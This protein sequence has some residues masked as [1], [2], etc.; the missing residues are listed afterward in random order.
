MTNFVRD[1]LIDDTSELLEARISSDG[2]Y[3]PEEFLRN[4]ADD[5]CERI[6]G[7]PPIQCP[8]NAYDARRGPLEEDQPE[9]LL[10]GCGTLRY[11]PNQRSVPEG[12]GGRASLPDAP[13]LKGDR[14]KTPGLDTRA[15]GRIH[16]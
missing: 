1:E 6:A 4:D 13:R 2:I 3:Q 5:I 12:P 7:E 10:Q 8:F 16:G 14:A 11:A 15:A 9:R